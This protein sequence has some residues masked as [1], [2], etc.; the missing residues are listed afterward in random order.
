MESV[1]TVV[2]AHRLAKEWH[3]EQMYGDKPYIHH[4]EMVVRVLEMFEWGDDMELLSAALLHDTM[5]DARITHAKLMDEFSESIA[6]LVQ[7]VTDK[8]GRNRRERHE[9]TYPLIRGNKRATALKLADRIANV[10]QCRLYSNEGLLA[11]Y[12]KEHNDFKAM[13]IDP[14]ISCAKLDMMWNYLNNLLAE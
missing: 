6:D 8:Q 3:G 11:M 13:L 1:M 5:E 14:A 9:R 7:L 10:I 2:K 4:C 12:Q